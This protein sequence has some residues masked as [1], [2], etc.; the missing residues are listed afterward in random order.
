MQRYPQS[1]LIVYT[2]LRHKLIKEKR[3][4]NKGDTNRYGRKKIIH[5]G[6]QS[7]NTKDSIRKFLFL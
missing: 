5:C 1:S 2:D 6:R 3:E 4:I 7:E